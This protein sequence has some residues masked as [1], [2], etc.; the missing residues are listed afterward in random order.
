METTL[1]LAAFAAV[2]IYVAVRALTTVQEIQDYELGLL[3]RR[4]S[5]AGT[6]G[7]G[8]HRVFGR[9]VN[10]EVYD[11]RSQSLS[12]GTQEVQTK[13]QVP[14][15]IN[16]TFTYRLEDAALAR[17][18]SANALGDLYRAVQLALREAV[19]AFELD[20][21]T[22]QRAEV[23][24]SIEQAV[25]PEAER[26]GHL[27]ERVALL[28]VIVRSE[29]KQALGEV[30]KARAEARAKLERARGES[31]ALRNLANSARLLKENE[32]LY[33]LRLL[34]T[35]QS[36][37]TSQSNSLVLGLREGLEMNGITNGRAH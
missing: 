14:V 5:F 28:D 7:T 8:V 12:L 30:V 34:E 26:L 22:G 32:G 6:L 10:V 18:V 25:R 4:G 23:A 24:S 35:A 9:R 16:V 29:I 13:D 11:V 21:L 27:I 20:Q 15:K 36:A 37:A 3:I 1:T 33:Q 19:Q 17:S 31:A 2:A